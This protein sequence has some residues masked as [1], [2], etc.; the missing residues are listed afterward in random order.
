VTIGGSLKGTYLYNADGQLVSRAVTNTTPSGTVHVLHDLNG[1][2]LVET[3][4]VG[5]TVREYIWLE[6]RGNGKGDRATGAA[7]PLAVVADVNTATAKL[8][9]VH[10]DHLDRPVMM[11]DTAATIVWQA[12]YLPFGPV[13][14]ITGTAANDN[15][16]PGQWYQLESGLSYNWHR[17]YDP[18]L[19]RYTQPDPLGLVDGPS[20]YAYVSS[21]PMQ[22]VDPRGEETIIIKWSP[23]DKKGGRWGHISAN[24]NGKTYSFGPEGWSKKYSLADDY[25]RRQYITN[26][27]SADITAL[28]LSK[29]E[30]IQFE[31]CLRGHQHYNAIFN[32]CGTPF[33]RCLGKQNLIGNY[34]DKAR[35]LPMDVHKIIR[36]SP[37]VL[38][39]PW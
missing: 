4:G 16:F 15:R 29:S 3:D 2:V 31:Q 17:H 14:S 32:N 9:R 36:S 35:V 11:T 24:I 7:T 23:A 6:H 38:E 27:R 1:N 5:N 13:Y 21:D 25:F 19:G 30:E 10:P 12:A 26:R 22:M 28:Y 18:S 8:Y 39:R 34:L 33:V 20:R 37:R